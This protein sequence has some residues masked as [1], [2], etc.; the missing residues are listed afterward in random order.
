MGR[1]IDYDKRVRASLFR[2]LLPP[3]PPRA[4]AAAG[5]L[6]LDQYTAVASLPTKDPKIQFGI[7][8]SAQEPDKGVGRRE[9]MERGGTRE[10]ARSLTRPRLAS[11][12]SQVI[13]AGGRA[14]KVAADNEAECADWKKHL[15]NAIATASDTYLV[16]L[17]GTRGR[18]W[19]PGV[20]LLGRENGIRH[21]WEDAKRAAAPLW[22]K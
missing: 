7:Q 5:E 15:G 10:L 16:S 18:G 4:R 14:L 20:S 8:V 11:T 22:A 2:T 17:S 9:R 12:S 21:L 1:S 6:E 3:A 13:V 19:G